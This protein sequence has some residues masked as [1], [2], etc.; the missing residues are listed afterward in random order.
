[1]TN[2]KR[3]DDSVEYGC[4]CQKSK[5]KRL[6]KPVKQGCGAGAGARAGAR[7]RAVPDLYGSTSVLERL[8]LDVS[9]GHIPPVPLLWMH[10]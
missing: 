7:A 4:P 1:M 2:L 9:G 6:N 8:T 5:M 10:A 3:S